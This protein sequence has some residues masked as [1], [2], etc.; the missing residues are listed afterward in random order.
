MLEFN[1]ICCVSDTSKDFQ[2]Q[3]KWVKGS[4]GRPPTNQGLVLVFAR[5][6]GT[7]P[8]CHLW[9]GGHEAGVLLRRHRY[10][11]ILRTGGQQAIL[12]LVGH[13]YRNSIVFHQI[14]DAFFL[15]RSSASW[16]LVKNMPAM[17]ELVPVYGRQISDARDPRP[18]VAE[19]QRD[20]F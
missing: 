6:Q 14:L 10:L 13:G 18:S 8:F 19:P 5:T 7:Q 11:G 2:D 12:A 1:G 16:L 3:W 17:L 20:P 15:P 9:R 4:I